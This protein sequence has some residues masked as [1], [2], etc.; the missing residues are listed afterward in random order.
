[1]TVAVQ[2]NGKARA[3]LTVPAGTA[4]DELERQARELPRIPELL[5]GKTIRRTIVVPDRI[6]NFV[7]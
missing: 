2:V 5:D 4:G 6:V 7:V 3:T 1:V